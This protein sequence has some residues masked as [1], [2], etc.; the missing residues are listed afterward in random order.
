MNTT[1]AIRQRLDLIGAAAITAADAL[2]DGVALD[3]GEGTLATLLQEND[4]LAGRLE[5]VLDRLGAAV[6]PEQQVSCETCPAAG[7]S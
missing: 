6:V 4:G 2:A 3:L 7:R 5:L 1:T